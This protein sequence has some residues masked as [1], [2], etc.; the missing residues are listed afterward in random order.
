M[1]FIIVLVLFVLL[2]GGVLGHWLDE[3]YDF[4]HP[5]EDLES[6]TPDYD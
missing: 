6:N 2:F 1:T 5:D 4:F 3:L